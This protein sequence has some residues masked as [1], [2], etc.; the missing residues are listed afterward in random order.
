MTQLVFPE[1]T[2]NAVY[3]QGPY[4]GRGPNPIS[5]WSDGLFRDGL[6]PQLVA[7]TGNPITG[8]SATARIEIAI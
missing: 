4:A 5:G 2:S 1:S 6:A 7:L 3:R 8:F